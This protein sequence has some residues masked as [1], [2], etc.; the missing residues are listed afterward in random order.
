MGDKEPQKDTT[1]PPIGIS[2][3][4]TETEKLIAGEGFPEPT[5]ARV[6]ENPYTGGALFEAMS[7]VCD[8][9]DSVLEIPGIKDSAKLEEI[10]V[11]LD[12]WADGVELTTGRLERVLQESNGF[13]RPIFMIWLAFFRYL[14]TKKDTDFYNLAIADRVPGIVSLVEKINFAHQVTLGEDFPENHG[15]TTTDTNTPDSNLHDQVQDFIKEFQEFQERLSKIAP[16]LMN[17]LK[18]QEES[19]ESSFLNG[20]E[21]LDAEWKTIH[22]ERLKT[23]KDL[24]PQ[25]WYRNNLRERFLGI[26]NEVSEIISRELWELYRNVKATLY[27]Q[28][29]PKAATSSATEAGIETA[30]ETIKGKTILGHDSTYESMQSLAASMIR[31]APRKLGITLSDIAS[32]FS[33]S[34]VQLKDR[35]QVPPPPEG[36]EIGQ[37][38]AFRCQFCL[39]MVSDI[40]T[41]KKWRKH[42]LADI[43]PYFCTFPNCDEATVR[44]RSKAEWMAH[45]VNSHRLRTLW[46]CKFSACAEFEEQTGFKTE[47]ELISHHISKHNMRHGV[48]KHTVQNLLNSSRTAELDPSLS[49]CRICQQELPNKISRLASH[50]GR[51][52]EDAALP[53]LSQLDDR[54]CQSDDSA[55]GACSDSSNLDTKSSPRPETAKYVYSE[56]D[57]DI[58]D[59]RDLDGPGLVPG[60]HIGIPDDPAYSR[61]DAADDFESR[62]L[63]SPWSYTQ[64]AQRLAASSVLVGAYRDV[65]A[66]D[67]AI[68][69]AILRARSA[70]NLLET[71][72]MNELGPGSGDS[73]PKGTPALDDINPLGF[74]TGSDHSLDQRGLI[75]VTGTSPRPQATREEMHTGD[76]EQLGPSSS[77]IAQIHRTLLAKSKY[78]MEPCLE[79]DLG[80]RLQILSPEIE[81][82]ACEAYKFFGCPLERIGHPSYPC[83]SVESSSPRSPPLQFS[84]LAGVRQHLQKA[85]IHLFSEE[86]LRSLDYPRAATWNQ[87]FLRLFLSWPYDQPIPPPW[88][89]HKSLYSELRDEESTRPRSNH[90]I[91]G[92][93][94]LEFYIRQDLLAL[95]PIGGFPETK[96]QK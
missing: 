43:R 80:M 81:D 12:L 62:K 94:A 75:D 79:P 55:V 83:L 38:E 90:V 14:I 96:G 5:N 36:V 20:D 4:M 27:E 58:G 74:S 48:E 85:H 56:R 28:S 78:S 57:I 33:N 31:P 41:T 67:N 88:V 23:L 22:E 93:T 18:D 30:A 42:V 2:I 92:S 89:T 51:H 66:A 61:L 46:K 7:L 49:F 76:E 72:P 3:P 6:G 64:T 29:I 32:N 65:L 91:D 19:R 37:V 17:I 11:K 63:T 15:D 53:I 70:A 8:I 73:G 59:L 1:V 40:D 45:E 44:Y 69:K 86:A 10:Q 71:D 39:E 52:L 13:K 21:E 50:I 87:V 60:H 47:Q 54:E 16:F 84:T 24:R 25:D 26:D 77:Q 68:V 9:V 95:T 35:P 34:S 82:Q